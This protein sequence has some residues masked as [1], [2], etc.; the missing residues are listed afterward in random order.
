MVPLLSSH[1]LKPPPEEAGD[2]VCTQCLTVSVP[3][4]QGFAWSQTGHRR[5][6]ESSN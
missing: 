1:P 4:A 6:E 5:P 3:I 2:N